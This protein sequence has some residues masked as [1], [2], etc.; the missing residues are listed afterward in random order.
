MGHESEARALPVF[1]RPSSLLLVFAGGVLGTL[2][3]EIVTL[4]VPPVGRLPLGV[5]LVNLLGAFLLGL[6]L[7]SLAH[8]GP[9]TPSGLRAR[10]FLGTGLLGG[11]TTYSTLAEAVAALVAGGAPGLAAAYGVGTVVLGAVATGAGVLLAGLRRRRSPSGGGG[12]D[13]GGTG[14]NGGGSR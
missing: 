14:A 9:E 11:F 7:E 13:G 12:G 6:L 4:V 2:L 3:R 5:L 8:R 10:L 1:L